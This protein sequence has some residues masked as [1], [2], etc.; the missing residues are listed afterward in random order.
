M[1][2]QH[3]DPAEIPVGLA[4][5]AGGRVPVLWAWCHLA[6]VA[7]TWDFEAMHVDAVVVDLQHGN[8]DIADLA[9]VVPHLELAGVAPV[10]R[11]LADDAG[12]IGRVLDLGVQAVIVP[13]VESA[14]QARAALDACRYAP[15][16]TRS[17]GPQGRF[18]GEP[19]CIVQI[20]TRAALDS[21][22]EIAAVDGLAAVYVGPWDLGL[23]LSADQPG[24][25]DDPI[26]QEAVRH[27]AEAC[28]AVGRP[29]GVHTTDAIGAKR[30]GSWGAHLLTVAADQAA[31][32]QH[33]FAAGDLAQRLRSRSSTEGDVPLCGKK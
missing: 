12:H 23:A 33:A 29:W 28:R 3:P 32:A 31:L 22:A 6:D 15:S 5:L 20:E 7:R 18:R 19:A 9:T 1:S 16:G 14:A 26:I 11:L 8:A 30:A 4:A 17:F 21:A 25:L 24:Q 27:V 13:Q 10:V 2:S